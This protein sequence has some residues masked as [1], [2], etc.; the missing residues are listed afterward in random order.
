[1][2]VCF[3]V[4]QL[5][6]LFAQTGG[7]TL[8]DRRPELNRLLN[9][10][11]EYTLRTQPELATHVGDD[12][13]NDR[14]SDFSGQA[15]AADLEHARQSLARFEAVDVTGFPEQE[16]LNRAL[17]LRS[18]R[19]A[20]ESAPFKDWEMPAT[21]F[22]GIHLGYATLA[23]DTPFR[24]AKDYRDYTGRLRQIPR[25]LDQAME[26][27]RDGLR[28]HRIPPRY[29]LET[30]SGQAQ[31]IAGY[32]LDKSPFTAPLRKFPDSISEAE[33]KPL[34]EGIESAVRDAVAPAYAKFARFVRE[35]Y[36]VG[37]VPARVQATSSLV[38]MYPAG[39]EFPVPR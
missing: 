29:L 20:L 24:N 11:W 39:A 34:R 6:P 37:Q 15:I 2:I 33:R 9:D 5:V 23:L 17:M 10:E 26:H 32:P 38:V 16:K 3:A 35:D 31:E 18:L 27:M 7:Q 8:K 21:Q 4:A 30:V 36:A 28:D 12:R 13:Y 25:V 1:M 14:L 22:G 19:E